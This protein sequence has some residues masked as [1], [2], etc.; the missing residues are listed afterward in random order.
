LSG[1]NGS[2]KVSGEE[3]K[4]RKKAKYEQDNNYRAAVF[5][6]V[7]DAF[8][9]V[10]VIAAI[11]IAG[12]V[13]AAYF[14]DPLVAIIGSF[15]ILS[16]AYTLIYDTS[17]N[18]LDVAPDSKLNKALK[19]VLENDGTVVY[20]LHVCLSFLFCFVFYLCLNFRCGGLGLVI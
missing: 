9:S 18:L 6:V 14:L 17:S 2:G 8:V 13:K 11:V 3:S 15:V 5:H 20:D 10:L 16:W 4:K 1:S 7:A 12:N 19:R